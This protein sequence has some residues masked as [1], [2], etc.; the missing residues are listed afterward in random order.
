M[1]PG[2]AV[3]VLRGGHLVYLAGPGEQRGEGVR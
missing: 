1:A 3:R 2:F